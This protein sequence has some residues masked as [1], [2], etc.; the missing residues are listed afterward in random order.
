MKY[1]QHYIFLSRGIR[2]HLLCMIR[3]R[4]KYGKEKE[5]NKSKNNDDNYQ[6]FRD[7][8]CN[9]LDQYSTLHFPPIKL[10]L[11]KELLAQT[12]QINQYLITKHLQCECN[13]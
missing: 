12:S 13:R 7:R 10:C 6:N 5:K 4:S 8:R 11:S 9:F 1:L 2:E 3:V